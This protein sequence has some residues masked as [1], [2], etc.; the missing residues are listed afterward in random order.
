M[1]NLV[2]V[3]SLEQIAVLTLN[4]PE[5]D[6]ALVPELLNEL[7]DA[8][9][10]LR[11]Q[12]RLRALVLQANGRSFSAG[13]DVRRFLDHLQ[14]IQDY[15]GFVVGQ[16][17]E[18][19]LALVAFPVPIVAAVQ[20]P[21]AGGSLGFVLASDV[22]LVA[23]DAAFAPYFGAIGFGPDGGWTAML[24]GVIGRKRAANVLLLDQPITA[25][26]AVVWGLANRIVPAGEIRAEAFAIAAA[27]AHQQPGS[28]QRTKRLLWRDCDRLAARL[29]EERQ[30]FVQQIATSEAQFGMA[31]HVN[32]DKSSNQ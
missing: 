7:L 11:R 17:N 1:S 27:I 19:I 14:D 32:R 5:R 21:S 4:H 9:D 29:E 12:A 13:D 10:G 24:P 16:L 28:V 26:Q 30:Q 18:A 23:P 22:V 3:E 20:G 8:L 25:E 15:G 6:N 2:L 31:A